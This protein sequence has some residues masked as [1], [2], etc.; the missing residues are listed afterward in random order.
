MIFA[1]DF[2]QLPPP[3]VKL[4][5]SLYTRDVG[6]KSSTINGQKGAAGK[7][8]WHQVVTVV[9]LRKN[10]RQKGN[11]LRNQ[12]FRT[13][14]SN[15][16]YKACTLDDLRTLS[17]CCH[18]D[19]NLAG[20]KV[21]NPEFRNV[22]IITALN[23]CKDR[24]N[25][26]GTERFANETNQTLHTFY[27]NDTMSIDPPSK[28]RK[29]YGGILTDEIQNML[30]NMPAS[31]HDNIPG[32]LKLCFGLPV[33]IRHNFATELCITKG[34]EG[35]VYGWTY[36]LGNKKQKVLDTVFVKLCNPPQNV[37][38]EN[39]PAN[40]VPVPYYHS[41]IDCQLRNDTHITVSRAQVHIV[42][43]FAMTDYASQGKTREFNVV[44]LKY[45]KNHQSIYT[46]LSRGTTIEGTLIIDDLTAKKITGGC[47]GALRQEFREL[48]LL[49]FI[50]KLNY[51]S[52]LA[53]N[54]LSSTRR[55]TLKNFQVWK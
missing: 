51:D 3:S 47:T 43:N 9:I 4:G 27:S 24:I 5:S 1:G 19:A 7:A 49:D 44:H 38:F 6:L 13:A 12:K 50:T 55:A 45:S 28:K 15:M 53:P 21:T 40:V 33:M 34:Q 22:S 26:L 23:I 2:A 20:P 25:E 39:L 41:T 18:V 37:Q 52:E 14:L 8:L 48:E 32:K 46:A 35:E 10:M 29:T 30:W 54:I 31:F 17:T 42:P 36:R 11:S 16:R